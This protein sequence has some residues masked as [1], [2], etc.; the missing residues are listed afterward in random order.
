MQEADARAPAVVV[1]CMSVGVPR[2]LFV[3]TENPLLVG[4]SPSVIS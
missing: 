2:F 4:C 3:L 1:Q